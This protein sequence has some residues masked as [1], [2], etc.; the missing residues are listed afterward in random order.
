MSLSYISAWQLEAAAAGPCGPITPGTPAG[1]PGPA[2]P[3]HS[4][5]ANATLSWLSRIA[6]TARRIQSF[7]PISH[8]PSP[9]SV[10]HRTHSPYP[11]LA[12]RSVSALACAVG[13]DS[14]CLAGR[15]PTPRRLE[16]RPRLLAHRLLTQI[17]C[18]AARW[19]GRLVRVHAPKET[20]LRLW[21]AK[22]RTIS[23]NVVYYVPRTVS[24]VKGL[25]L[26]AGA[27]DALMGG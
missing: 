14:G 20:A 3:R 16:V 11:T 5:T 7:F 6:A 8:A 26:R 1:P 9:A 27:L 17:R 23:L 24:L 2:S 15:L 21:A 22:R 18:A 13:R 4:T 19:R 25:G 12:S 10:Q